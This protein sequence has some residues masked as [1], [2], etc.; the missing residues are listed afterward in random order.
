MGLSMYSNNLSQIEHESIMEAS[1]E[2]DSVTDSNDVFNDPS[3]RMQLKAN[4]KKLDA[5][6]SDDTI[7][8]DKNW[9]AWKR[10]GVM[11][12]NYYN[13]QWFISMPQSDKV[14]LGNLRKAQRKQGNERPLNVPEQIV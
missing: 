2:E 10:I 13:Q 4:K 5:L 6:M 12:D 7:V 3:I 11:R 9:K 14:Q 1:N 8:G